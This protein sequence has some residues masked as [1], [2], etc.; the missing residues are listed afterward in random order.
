[1]PVS[2]R[3]DQG[4]QPVAVIDR[5]TTAGSADLA[6]RYHEVRSI[7]EALAAP[8]SAE[9]QVV[10]SMPDVSPTKWHRAHVTWFF[11]TFLLAP[12][13]TG[14]DADPTFGFLFNS[15]YEAVGARHPRPKRGLLTRPSIDAIAAYRHQVDEAMDRL[16]AGPAMAEPGMRE[17]VELGLHH[18]QQH[19]ELLLM[20]I[21]HVL[22]ST[23]LRSPYREAA[24]TPPSANPVWTWVDFDGGV[25]DIGHDGEHF[26]FDNE[27][28]A[29]QVLLQPYRLADRAV[30]AGD[31]QL[32]IDDGGYRT[33][34]L[35]LSDGW[36]H[37]NAQGWDAP[38]YWRLD[39]DQGWMLHT[40]AGERPVDPAEPVVHISYYEADAFARWAGARLPTEAEWETAARPLPVE[41]NLLPADQLHPAPVLPRDPTAADPGLRQM[42]GDVWEWTSSP[43][44]AY[45]GFR[46]APGAVGEYNGKFMVDQQVLRGGCAVTPGGHVRATYRNF[47]PARARWQFGGLR[48]AADR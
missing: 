34:E 9:D 47:F 32:F 3:P 30:T 46:P 38:E 40:L 25:V 21:K 48:L 22:G 12:N 45:P 28:P 11:E 5:P 27:G 39:E 41:G 2:S 31:W 24:T 37:S 8:L 36:H 7:T 23:I 1:M 33:A 13:L 44:S 35:W 19:Q 6:E 17:L 15:Y 18:E 14:Y 4:V 29:H 26:A 20:D 42:F 43:Y 16:L 10:Q